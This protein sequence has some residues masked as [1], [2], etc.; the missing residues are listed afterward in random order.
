VL[1]NAVVGGVTVLTGLNP[2]VVAAHFLAAVLLLTT[3]TVSYDIAQRGRT[4]RSRERDGR[5]VASGALTAWT[6]VIGQSVGHRLA[7]RP[8]WQGQ[9]FELHAMG[10][11]DDRRTGEGDVPATRRP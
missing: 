8:S 5:L 1:L 10:G 9:W 4:P 7:R 3:T 2:Y 6:T 11:Q